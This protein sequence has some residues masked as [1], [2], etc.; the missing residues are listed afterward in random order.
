MW[1]SCWLHARACPCHS[2]SLYYQP[3][4]NTCQSWKSWDCCLGR[5]GVLETAEPRNGPATTLIGHQMSHLFTS[6]LAS[7]EQVLRLCQVLWNGTL[8]ASKENHWRL[9][10]GFSHIKQIDR[11]KMAKFV[12][13]L[14]VLNWLGRLRI[15]SV[16]NWEMVYPVCQETFLKEISRLFSSMGEIHDERHPRTNDILQEDTGNI[17]LSIDSKWIDVR[18]E[19]MIS[20]TV[21]LNLIMFFQNNFIPFPDQII[22]SI[23]TCIDNR[24]TKFFR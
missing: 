20:V 7:L 2:S 3:N 23:N 22:R 12:F 5:D 13:H 8:V 14:G 4:M 1:Y 17:G 9:L 16:L 18:L 6:W 19:H 15:T 24:K 10:E 21:F 11:A